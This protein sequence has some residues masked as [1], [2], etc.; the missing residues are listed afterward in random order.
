MTSPSQSPVRYPNGVSTDYTWGPLADFGNENPFMYQTLEDDLFGAFASDGYWVTQASGTG[1]SVAAAAGDGGIWLLTNGSTVNLSS[2]FKGVVNNFFLPP[3]LF[4]GSGLTA[5]LFPSKKLWFLARMA[6]PVIA[7]F[8]FTVGLTPQTYATG[9]PTDGVVVQMAAGGATMNLNAYSGSVLQWSIPFPASL[10]AGGSNAVIA[11]NSWFDVGFS[12]D[13]SLN[14]YGLLG[15]PLVGWQPAS[16]WTGTNNVNAAPTDKAKVCA[17]QGVYNGQ[18]VTPWT[19]TALGLTPSI[20]TFGSA[21][22]AQVD[23]VMASKER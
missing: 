11:N 19:P 2:G 20:T 15:W 13:R 16:A 5:T 14:V 22:T 17:F 7:G 1:S 12:I 8:S 3:A 4:T 21:L 6:I 10:L 9:N 23:F 18:I